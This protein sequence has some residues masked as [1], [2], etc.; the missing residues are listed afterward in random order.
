MTKIYLKKIN[1][2]FLN[3]YNKLVFKKNLN[4]FLKR[5]N[6]KD[7]NVK[8][9]LSKKKSYNIVTLRAPKHFKVGRHHY[10]IISKN[11]LLTIYCVQNYKIINFSDIFCYMN[12]IKFILKKKKISKVISLLKKFTITFQFKALFFTF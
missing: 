2:S 7:L 9:C 6:A 11:L 12:R 4:F 8:F 3:Y 5:N 10:H 1:Y